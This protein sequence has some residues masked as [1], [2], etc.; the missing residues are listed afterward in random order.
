MYKQGFKLDLYMC[1]FISP[2]HNVSYC[3][4]NREFLQ[5]LP[6]IKKKKSVK[7]K[8]K[9]EKFKDLLNEILLPYFM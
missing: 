6:F 9:D 2:N 1:N 8:K 4:I 7:L 5:L 3:Y